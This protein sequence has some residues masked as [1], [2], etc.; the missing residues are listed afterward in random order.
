MVH[1]NYKFCEYTLLS[2]LEQHGCHPAALRLVAW[3]RIEQSLNTRLRLEDELY[4]I[5]GPLF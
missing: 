2:R 4:V 5:T 1:A 3:L